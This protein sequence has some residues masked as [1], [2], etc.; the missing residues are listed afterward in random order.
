MQ[1]INQTVYDDI[2]LEFG[3]SPTAEETVLDLAYVFQQATRLA[4][5]G[6]ACRANLHSGAWFFFTVMT[7]IDT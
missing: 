4:T 1:R 7:T 5:G 2:Q 6:E 3:P